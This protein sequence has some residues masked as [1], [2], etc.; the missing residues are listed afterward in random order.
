MS[1][2]HKGHS[3]RVETLHTDCGL[4]EAFIGPPSSTTAH[5]SAPPSCC[6]FT[7]H[8][9]TAAVH[10]IPLPPL[11]I[12]T[13]TAAHIYIQNGTGIVVHATLYAY[14]PGLKCVVVQQVMWGPNRFW[15]G[16]GLVYTSSHTYVGPT[17]VC[18]YATNATVDRMLITNNAITALSLGHKK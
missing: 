18:K 12:H 16:S 6:C 13:V 15:T 2:R 9:T 5:K 3:F 1:R 10:F 17:H 14:A 7:A 8:T 4:P 11:Y